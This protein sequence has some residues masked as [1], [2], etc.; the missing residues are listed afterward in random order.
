MRML[1]SE[2]AL[3]DFLR[4]ALR[5]PVRVMLERIQVP[6]DVQADRDYDAETVRLLQQMT[7]AAS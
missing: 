3:E 6:L 5:V 7:E 4:R 1:S 2:L